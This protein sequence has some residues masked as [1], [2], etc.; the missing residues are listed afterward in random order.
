MVCVKK[1]GS[2]FPICHKLLLHFLCCQESHWQWKTDYLSGKKPLILIF[3]SGAAMLKSSYFTIDLEAFTGARRLTFVKIIDHLITSG[4]T[5]SRYTCRQYYISVMS[6]T[7][8][9]MAK[10]KQTNDWISSLFSSQ[11]EK[12]VFFSHSR[13]L[14]IFLIDK[15]NWV[16]TSWKYWYYFPVISL[17]L[18]CI[19]SMWTHDFE[20]FMCMS[21]LTWWNVMQLYS[22]SS[23]KLCPIADANYLLWRWESRHVPEEIQIAA[24]MLV[25]CLASACKW[26]AYN[27]QKGW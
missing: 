6:N 13:W 17:L 24:D 11:E 23:Q 4:H 18:F 14:K 5:W 8:N 9:C 15:V 27:Q 16:Y 20:N 1:G 22:L 10:L 21:A 19:I 7:F 2:C 25:G 12:N 3:F 26:S